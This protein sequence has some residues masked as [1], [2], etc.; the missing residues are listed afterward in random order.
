MKFSAVIF[1]FNGVLLWDEALQVE[2]WQTA[3]LELRGSKLSED[4]FLTHVH[5]RTNSHVLSHLL[6]RTV[7]EQDL[8]DLIQFKE[9]IYRRLCLAN[10][11]SFVM[12]PGSKSLLSFLVK[13]GTPI[14]IATAS[15]ITNL[16]FFV[17]QLGLEEWFNLDLIVYDNG[18]LP[19]KPAPDV[20]ALAA[21]KLEQAP[22]K[23]IVVED[24]VSGFKS[25]HAAGIGHVI[26]LGPQSEHLRL[27]ACAEVST[28]IESLEQFPRELLHDA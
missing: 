10:P 26:G 15:E 23:C 22:E 18:F 14:T 7:Q 12:S 11:E 21:Q 3:A 13:R 19:G 28:V 6:E 24:A 4:E 2:A 9:S 8:L 27:K 20:Y 25:A 5:G 16:K 1:D 17:T